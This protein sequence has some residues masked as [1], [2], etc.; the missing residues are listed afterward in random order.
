MKKKIVDVILVVIA[1]CNGVNPDFCEWTF[2]SAPLSISNL[3][4]LS[5]PVQMEMNKHTNAKSFFFQFEID[6]R[7]FRFIKDF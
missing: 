6:S 7:I 5:A 2:T 1:N 4:M 3:D